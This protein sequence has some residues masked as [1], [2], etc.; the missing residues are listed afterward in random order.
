[1]EEMGEDGGSMGAWEVAKGAFPEPPPADASASVP[2]L[3][4]ATL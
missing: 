3:V 1:M 2:T 4:A